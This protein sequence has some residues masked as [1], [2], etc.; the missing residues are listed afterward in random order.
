MLQEQTKPKMPIPLL[1]KHP[2]DLALA[3]VAAGID[4][5]LQQLR[6]LSPEDISYNIALTLDYI[7]FR[8]DVSERAECIRKRALLLI[9][10]TYGWQ[11]EVTPDHTRLRLSGGST[12]IELALSPSIHEYILG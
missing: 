10:R 7:P 11:A 8:D 12:P 1:P 2:A 3:P 5:N 6:D 9:K 4:H